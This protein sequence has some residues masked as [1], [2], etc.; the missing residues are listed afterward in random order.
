MLPR[1]TS[2]TIAA[3]LL[4]GGL[5]LG[6]ALASFAGTAPGQRGY[7]GQPGHQGGG[8]HGHHGTSNGLQGYEGQPGNQGGH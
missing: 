6:S 4:T 7:E 5:V 2:R 8:Q 3:A 1:T